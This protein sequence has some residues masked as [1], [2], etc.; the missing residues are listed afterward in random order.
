MRF[1]HKIR[2]LLNRDAFDSA[3]ATLLRLSYPLD[4]Q[5][6]IDAIDRKAFDAIKERYFNPTDG[7]S[8]KKYLNL[9][10]LDAHER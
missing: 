3:R 6:F 4:A 1:S 7:V 2:K 5:P 8:P 9:E 10:K